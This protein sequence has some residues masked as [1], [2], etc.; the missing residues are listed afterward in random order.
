MAST[1]VTD[2]RFSQ[3]RQHKYKWGILLCCHVCKYQTSNWSEFNYHVEAYKHYAA[4]KC[5]N[6]S[7][8]CM[9]YVNSPEEMKKHHD[10]C[11][12]NV[13]KCDRCDSEIVS[14]HKNTHEIKCIND[15]TFKKC[16]FCSESVKHIN[17]CKHITSCISSYDWKYNALT[18]LF[19][20]ELVGKMITTG[21][22]IHEISSEYWDIASNGWLIHT[23]E[24]A[25]LRAIIVLKIRKAIT[26]LMTF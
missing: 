6:S 25:Y 24:S 12:S 10:E 15:Q 21:D 5:D 18:D 11:T 23:T 19:T 20:Q 8:G 7:K 1:Y 26:K 17:M 16:P 4:I 14:V 13:I 3:P 22:S 2:F 9:Y